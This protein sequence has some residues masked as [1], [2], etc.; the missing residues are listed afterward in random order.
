MKVKFLGN[1]S[2]IYG[3]KGIII[4]FA[5]GYAANIIPDIESDTQ[6]SKYEVSKVSKY[7]EKMKEFAD[8]IESELNDYIIS[9][10]KKY[11]E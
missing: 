8:N 10:I 2:N 11:L 4:V 7:L 6:N 1:F 9:E 3:T 5:T